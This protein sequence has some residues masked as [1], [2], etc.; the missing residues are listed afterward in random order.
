L[1]AWAVADGT[2]ASALRTALAERLPAALVPSRVTVLPALPRL[3]NGKLN[4]RALTLPQDTDAEPAGPLEET[5]AATMAALL[6]VSAVAREA[7]FFA[8]GGHSLLAAQLAARLRDATGRDVQ[9]AALF[10]APTPAGL[11]R[12]LGGAPVAAPLPVLPRGVPLP[13]GAAQRRLWAADRLSGGDSRWTMGGPMVL[14]GKLDAG[15]IADALTAIVARHEPLRTRFVEDIDGPVQVVDPPDFQL[16]QAESEDLQGALADAAAFMARPFDL[17]VDR[18][19]RARLTRAEDGVSILSLAVHHIAA[20]GWSIGVLLRELAAQLSDT[21]PALPTVPRYADVAAWMDAQ[22]TGPALAWWR[23][24]LAGMEVL[25]LPGDGPRPEQTIGDAVAM[26]V[27]LDG[28][29]AGLARECGATRFMALAAGLAVALHEATGQTDICLGTDVADRRHAAAEGLIGFFA[30]QVVLRLDLAR[31]PTPRA[32]MGR[33]RAAT[34]GM[35]AHQHVSADRVLAGLPPIR[36]KITWQPAPAVPVTLAGCSVEWP[37]APPA[38]IPFDLL[39]NLVGTGDG[40]AGTALYRPAALRGG[41]VGGL[42]ARFA[43]LLTAMATT[44]DAP[45]SGLLAQPGPVVADVTGMRRR[46]RL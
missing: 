23:A 45:L 19:F 42:L 3:P 46:I 11:A 28:A 16:E 14:R 24:H 43:A 37:D 2:D 1:A 39:V 17:A 21:A 36:A 33:V 29:A 7:D 35:F 5:V 20:D 18:P 4:R 25:R 6:G 8:L 27:T 31:N 26:A 41:A 44:P 15:A 34:L 30:N 10:M 40:A 12:L 32:L 9:L 38:A 22:D 13:L